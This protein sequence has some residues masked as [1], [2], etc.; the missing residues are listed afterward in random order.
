[1]P[2]FFKRAKNRNKL[3]L[4]GNRKIKKNVFCERT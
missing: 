1:M 4:E 2:V 3:K